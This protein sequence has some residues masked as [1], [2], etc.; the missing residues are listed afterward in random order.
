M[1]FLIAPNAFKG[2]LEAAEAA[3][4]IAEL[5]RTLPDS[6]VQLQPVADGGDG[7][8]S[9]LI[10]SLNLD[11]I[12]KWTLNAVGQPCLGYFGWDGKRNTAYLDVSTASGLGTL[13]TF[14]KDPHTTSTFGTG[15]LIRSAVDFGAKEIV[16]GLGGSA[17]IDMGTG[18]LYALGV[19]FL[20]EHGR[21]L[22][23][24]SAR[25][26]EKIKH[27]QLSTFI[28]KVKFTLLCD[29]R[30][31]FF[32]EN[33]AISVFGPQ[34]GLERKDLLDFEESCKTLLSQMIRKS[35]RDWKD[36]P[37]FGAAGGIALGLDLFFFTEIRFGAEYFF[38]QTALKGK[39]E[40]ADWIIT[41]EGQYDSQSDQGK[42][43]FELLRLA[44]EAGKKVALITSGKGG[45][46]SGFDLV[47]ELP[48]LDFSDFD[49]KEKARQNLVRLMHQ[50][51]TEGKFN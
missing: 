25:F 22:S 41:G 48:P 31:P 51:L 8:C 49:Y 24:F 35:K 39:I 44:K 33:G 4:I 50:A 29:V 9:L 14:Q 47:L 30:N 40:F 11:K 32:G 10:D 37:G 15:L 20:D 16:L 27:I 19:L 5:I 3:K 36:S 12:H 7:T 45:M 6:Q 34:K 17:T 2:T 42:A 1:N 23:A 18:I 21:E 26:L 28:P 43:S 38:E 13:E 46:E